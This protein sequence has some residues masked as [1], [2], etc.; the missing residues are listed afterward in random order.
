MG[1]F[2]ASQIEQLSENFFTFRKQN[3]VILFNRF[4]FQY[5]YIEKGTDAK[6][7]R[8]LLRRLEGKRSKIQYKPS[9]LKKIRI[10]VTSRC[11]CSC[12]YCLVFKNDVPKM[13]LTMDEETATKVINFYKKNIKNGSVMIAG[14]EPFLAWHIVKLFLQNLKDEIKIFTNGTVINGE[15]LNTL[16][17]KPNVRLMVSLDG[18]EV[19]NQR[20]RFEGGGNVYSTVLENIKTFQKNSCQLS[21]SCLCTNETVGH[22]YKITQFF[23]KRLGIKSLGISFPHYISCD[24]CGNND[25]DIGKYTEQMLKIFDFAVKNQ[26]YVDQLAKRF[27]PLINKKFR[28]YS[29]KLVREQATFY[30]DGTTTLCTKID[31]L[32][33]SL[34]YNLAYFENI[35]PI[36]NKF[37]QNCFAIGI[38]GGGCFWD[39]IMRF[40][41][42]VDE[43]EC[44]FNKT[45]LDHFLWSIYWTNQRKIPL[46]EKYQS[47]TI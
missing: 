31:P 33:N 28:F 23:V 12:D 32:N 42:G 35:L 22:L 40:K 24:S 20:R 11:N 5:K 44:L 7:L 13:N 47:L 34:K 4:T 6:K 17:T 41:N 36:N 16:I 37:C 19:D 18:Q 2:Q 46:R 9:A 29:C 14:G 8:A 26:F 15:I 38:C 39:G 45:L 30:P 21:I 10:E 25:L 3:K 43:R 27:S 1:D